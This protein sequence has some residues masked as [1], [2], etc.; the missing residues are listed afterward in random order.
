MPS[1]EVP[2]P[3]SSVASPEALGHST[4]AYAA[5]DAAD[6]TAHAASP[7]MAPAPEK[8]AA[9]TGR[10]SIGPST[11]PFHAVEVAV[12]CTCALFTRRGYDPS[13]R[14]AA[15]VTGPPVVPA[16]NQLFL[17]GTVKW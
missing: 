13:P 16:H 7:V 11:S 8:G 12:S 5:A 9:P 17:N 10:T 4:D 2:E 3:S 15:T 1:A 6:A 14:S